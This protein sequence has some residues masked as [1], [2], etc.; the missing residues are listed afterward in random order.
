M[1]VATHQLWALRFRRWNEI[2]EILERT[3]DFSKLASKVLGELQERVRASKGEV[4]E[5]SSVDGD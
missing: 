1:G 4:G 2:L 3:P 5:T